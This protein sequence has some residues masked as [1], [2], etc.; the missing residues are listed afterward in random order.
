MK[1]NLLISVLSNPYETGFAPSLARFPNLAKGPINFLNLH[2]VCVIRA[3]TGSLRYKIVANYQHIFIKDGVSL[4][5]NLYVA[6][7]VIIVTEQFVCQIFVLVVARFGAGVICCCTF[8]CVLPGSPKEAQLR[9][10]VFF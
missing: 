4:S 7:W 1:I 3:Q 8:W 6:T 2:P 9:T 10:L 5:K